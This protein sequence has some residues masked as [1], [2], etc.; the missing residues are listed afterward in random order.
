[1]YPALPGLLEGNPF[2]EGGQLRL[3]DGLG[4]IL[5]VLKETLKLSKAFQVHPDISLQLCAYLFFF[6]NASMFN[7]LME[8]GQC[9]QRCP[10]FAGPV[11]ISML[12]LASLPVLSTPSAGSVGGFYQWS[13]GVQIRANL[14]LMMDWFQSIGL[15][16]LA[17]QFFQKLSAAV[18]LLATPKETLLQVRG[19]LFLLAPLTWKHVQEV[20]SSCA[21][22]GGG[23][24][25]CPARGQRSTPQEP[26]EP[27][28]GVSVPLRSCRS[29]FVDVYR[30]GKVAKDSCGMWFWNQTQ[31]QQTRLS[32][33]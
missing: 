2:S 7:A 18:N 9:L 31:T 3:P 28:G 21:T 25:L 33:S 27:C 1:M 29:L 8:R 24:C 20:M 16:E 4:S 32:R 13:R 11:D 10:W 6:I 14:D 17:T 15:G 19:R 30:R 22:V 26:S 23:A 12:T 5:E